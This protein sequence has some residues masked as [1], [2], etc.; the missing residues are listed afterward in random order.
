[1]RPKD[2]LRWR[3]TGKLSQRVE[4]TEQKAHPEVRLCEGAI[5]FRS[6][7]QHMC[8]LFSVISILLFFLANALGKDNFSILTLNTIYNSVGVPG[9]FIYST[10]SFIISY[11]VKERYL[12]FAATCELHL[13]TCQALSSTGA[14]IL[15]CSIN[16]Y[17]NQ[18]PG[19]LYGNLYLHAHLSFFMQMDGQD[20]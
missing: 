4:A 19:D 13:I 5:S 12:S 11:E 16:L 9:V 20:D 18:G 6:D 3:D 17:V 15:E 1:M 2:V 8:G 14:C 7:G 10:T